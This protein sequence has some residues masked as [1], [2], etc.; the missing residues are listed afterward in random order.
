MLRCLILAIVLAAGLPG[1]ATAQKPG[2]DCGKAS[3]AIER[4]VC[5]NAELVT[6]DRAMAAAY[7]ALVG[8]LRGAARDHL[9]ADQARWLVN[10]E[11]ACVGEPADVEECLIGRFR[12][13]TSLLRLLGDGA[14][15]FVSEQAIVKAGEAKGIPYSIDAS[16]PQFD[17]TTPDF[18][19]VNR[20]LAAA[21]RE[22]AERVVPGSDADTGGGKYN[23]AAWRY[24]QAF[25]LYRPSDNAVSVAL[26]YDSYEG[27]AYPVGGVRG[28]LVDL[29]TGRAV[30]P[31]GVFAPNLDWL[32]ELVRIA[33]GE[34]KA[35]NLPDLLKQPGRYVFL[36][37]RLELTF[38]QYE[39]G[40]Y[41][42]EIPYQRLKPLL[43]PDGPIP[44]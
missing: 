42:L 29:R 41:T 35:A 1:A 15:P 3:S 37:D 4:T 10:R 6:A 26:L 11:R 40:P 7:A 12:D 27:G 17:A 30:G 44:R 2:A 18:G 24:E 39:G 23:G 31:D 25:T 22:A 21:T 43:R 5:G 14:Y 16:Y 13:R 34:I 19:A 20:Q 9:T 33:G 8:K 38:N 32:K 36:D 28:M